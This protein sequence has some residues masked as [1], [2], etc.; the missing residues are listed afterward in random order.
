MLKPLMKQVA[1]M[2]SYLNKDAKR[3]ISRTGL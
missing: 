1:I 2:K 3:F